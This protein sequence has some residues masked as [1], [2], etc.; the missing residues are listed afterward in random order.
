MTEGLGLHWTRQ[1]DLDLWEQTLVT[2]SGHAATLLWIRRE[3]GPD[4]EED[5]G[6]PE[7]LGMPGFR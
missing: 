1:P 7:E 5:E 4:E 3:E 6:G 2:K